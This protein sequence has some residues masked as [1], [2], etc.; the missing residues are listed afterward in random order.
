MLLGLGVHWYAV[1]NFSSDHYLRFTEVSGDLIRWA[2][3]ASIALVDFI[4]SR[5]VGVHIV[6]GPWFPALT[7]CLIVVY[8]IYRIA[9]PN[10]HLAELSSATAQYLA[11]GWTLT[12]LSCLVAAFD[13]PFVD[14]TLAR[15][16]AA[17]GISWIGVFDFVH[18]RQWL[19]NVLSI[20]YNSIVPQ[21]AL[22]FIWLNATGRFERIYEFI[23]LF[24]LT[25]GIT[26]VV[27]A[28][29]PAAGAFVRYDVLTLVNAD[30]LSLLYGL[31]NGT[32][33]ELPLTKVD[34]IVTLPSFHTVLGILFIYAARKVRLLFPILAVANVIL[35]GATP[36]I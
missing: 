35:I 2:S 5:F 16:D 34:G 4:L 27:S 30:Y 15:V 21:T 3:I 1:A 18:T 29:V 36:I 23:S 26:V 11:L 6:M 32:I 10:T 19:N 22:L 24:A 17:L 33:S 20:G 14:A 7:I 31:R 9:R 28:F 25:L 8:A 13:F 12:V